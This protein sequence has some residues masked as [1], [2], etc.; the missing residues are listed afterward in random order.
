[1]SEYE[2]Y[3]GMIQ[4]FP[5]LKLLHVYLEHIEHVA[6]LARAH[7]ADPYKGVEERRCSVA[8]RAQREAL[9]TLVVIAVCS[10]A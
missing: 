8:R 10:V 4:E 2:F 5:F 6:W 9:L 1:M 3:F 7:D